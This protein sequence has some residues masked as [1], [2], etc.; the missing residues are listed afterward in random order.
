MW[1]FLKIPKAVALIAFVLP[2]LTVSCTNQVL[3]RASGWALATGHIT[4]VNPINGAAELPDNDPNKWLIAA[5]VVIVVG[6]AASF[7]ARRVGAGATLATS[8][9]A[10]A[11]VLIGTHR[12]SNEALTD[13]VHR[14]S[15]D[16]VSERMAAAIKVEWQIGYW[17][18]IASLVVAAGM[19]G[20]MVTGRDRKIAG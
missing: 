19:A 8:L 10:L 20:M 4:V 13:A 1:R 7:L 17:L 5:L 14:R 16:P 12:I 6:L 3:V 2:W 15:P 9:A 18:E 11:L